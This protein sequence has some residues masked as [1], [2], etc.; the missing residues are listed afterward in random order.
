MRFICGL[1]AVMVWGLLWSKV[2][3]DVSCQFSPDTI[4]LSC[5]IVMAGGMAGGGVITRKITEGK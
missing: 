1:I 5:S 3:Q 2:M 4:M